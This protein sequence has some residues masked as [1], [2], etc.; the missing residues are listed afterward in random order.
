MSFLSVPTKDFFLKSLDALMGLYYIWLPI[1]LAIIF[2]SLWVHYV[3]AKYI[4]GIS[5]ILLEMKVPRDIAKSPRAMEVFLNS[6][7]TTRTGNFV[8]QYWQGF[9]TAWFSLEIVGFNGEVHFYIYTQKFFRKIVEA[10]IYAQYPNVE[11]VEA[12]DYTNISNEQEFIQ[13]WDMFGSEFAL[14]AED[15]YPIKTYIDYGLH[16]LATKEEQKT[17]PLT[18]FIEFLG[19]LGKD[20]QVWFQILIR[21]TKKKWK[22]EGEKLIE[23][24]MGIKEGVDDKDMIQALGGLHPGKTDLI[25]AVQRD[26][27]KLGYDVGMRMIYVAKKEV[28]D[29]S[30]L[31]SML[32]LTKQYN[33]PNL[34][35]FKPVN[36]TSVDYLFKKTRENLR[37]NIML[38]AYK[39]RSCFY[40]PYPRKTFILNTEELATIYHFPGRVSE[41]PTFGR[42]EAKK[43]SPPPN[44]PI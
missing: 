23:K 6:L 20:E 34:N 8:E 35:G 5:W 22:E 26:I 16:E 2:W 41:T 9:L 3:R 38:N 31:V 43:S 11:I 25:K 27:S 19:S 1:I 42:I 10:Q 39:N 29:A 33:S 7:H 17:D 13:E 24:V 14:I 15:P 18:S 28:Y 37:R 32:L 21:A 12:S 44:L 30:R 36:I 40:L 4:N